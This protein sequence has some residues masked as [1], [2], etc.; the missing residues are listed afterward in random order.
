MHTCCIIM[1]RLL[2]IGP[3]AL[4]LS[5]ALGG[6][7]L[8][9]GDAPADTD[10]CTTDCG[11]GADASGDGVGDVTGGDDDGVDPDGGSDDGEPSGA[12]IPCDIQQI[13][14]DN[15]GECHGDPPLYG[16]PMALEDHVDFQ[17]PAPSDVS[18]SVW[19]EAIDR[20][21]DPVSP[22]PPF[23]EM[24]SDDR[25][26][27]LAWLEAGAPEEENAGSCD[28]EPTDP[29]EPVGPDAL[30][31]DVTHTFTAHADASEE[32]YHVPEQGADNLYQCFTFS[33]PV[34]E[35]TQATAWA[36]IIDDERVVHHW[37]LYRSATPQV[38][39][40]VG[41]CDMPGDAKFVAGWAPGGKNFLMPEGVGLELGGPDD[42]YIL[43]IHYHNTAHHADS[44]DGSG[45]AFCTAEEPL[46]QTAGIMTLGTVWLDIPAGAEGHEESGV[47]PS[48]MTSFLPEPL[49]VIASFPHMHELGRSF[50]TE[51]LRGGDETDTDAITEVPLY[52]FENQ[53][54]YVNDPP[55]QIM[56]GDAIRTT[57]TYDNPYDF[58]VRFGEETEDE[59]CFNFVMAYPIEMVGETRDCGT[60]DNG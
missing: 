52:N 54:F 19:E 55:L 30:P 7:V 1:V 34:A 21:G 57:C 58:T 50:S 42:S 46:P 51:I 12:G 27:L 26:A 37:I 2:E 6:C 9:G 25:E 11:D 36:P 3:L 33:S 35:G 39:G 17:I 20:I 47:C 48:W 44:F 4:L 38:D 40:G 22:M 8:P 32:P 18:R 14:V 29:G 60:L 53:E 5:F 28:T 59:M 10:A 56:P 16:A 13:L 45:V 31:C 49:T 15:C 23:G 41:P 43:Q 24:E